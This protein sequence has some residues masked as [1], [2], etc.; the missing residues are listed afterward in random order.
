[1]YRYVCSDSTHT[2]IQPTC[3]NLS[4]S[5]LSNC[6]TPPP[7]APRCV[8]VCVYDYVCDCLIVCVC[9]CV[10]VCVIVCVFVCV[11]VCVCVC[12]CVVSSSGPR[13]RTLFIRLSSHSARAAVGKHGTRRRSTACSR[14]EGKDHSNYPGRVRSFFLCLC[15][16]LSLSR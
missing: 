6:E 16:S 14:R 3:I 11:C 10:C 4:V 12:G 8:C 7:P 1:M 9:V 15:L 5:S 2:H 13:D